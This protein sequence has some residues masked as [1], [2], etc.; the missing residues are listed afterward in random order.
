VV[1]QNLTTRQSVT[2]RD[3][4]RAWNCEAAGLVVHEGDKIR[5][6]VTGTR[7]PKM[8]GPTCTPATSDPYNCR[9]DMGQ[10]CLNITRQNYP[11]EAACLAN[12]CDL[13][14]PANAQVGLSSW[15]VYNGRAI[16][17]YASAG[18][19][20]AGDFCAADTVVP[21]EALTVYRSDGVATYCEYEG[22]RCPG[23]GAPAAWELPVGMTFTGLCP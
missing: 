6:T 23:S 19:Y 10:L 18:R 9:L 12:L 20:R 2:L 16:K 11:T 15:C 5:Q 1:C 22:R 3:G 21:Y 13:Y 4:A 14:G 7:D 17:G 8:H